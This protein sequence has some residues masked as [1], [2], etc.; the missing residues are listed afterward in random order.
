MYRYTTIFNGLALA[1]A[2]LVATPAVSF[3]AEDPTLDAFMCYKTAIRSLRQK[4]SV[5][6]S[7]AF[8]ADN[9]GVRKGLFLCAPADVEGAGVIDEDTHLVAYRA[10]GQHNS[11]SNVELSDLFGSLSFNTSKRSMM[12]MVPTAKSLDG[13]AGDP[14]PDSLV[15]HFRCLRA[16]ETE[17]TPAFEGASVTVVDQ[18][19][20]RDVEVRQVR[21]ICVPT[22]KNDEGIK[23]DSNYLICYRVDADPKSVNIDAQISNQFGATKVRV[24]RAATLCMPPVPVC[25]PTAAD[26][27]TC[28][29]VD[30]DCDDLVDEDYASTA[31]SCGVGACAA[32]GS[33]SCVA[34]A[35][36]DSC[37][38]G[39]P[40]N[41]DATC[42]GVDDDCD[43]A[44]DEDYV[45]QA[46]SCG[47]GACASTG[48]TSCVQGSV[49]DSCSAGSPAQ[50][51]ATCDGVDDDC[52]GTA[53]EDY[54]LNQTY[55]G[56]AQTGFAVCQNG[57]VGDTCVPE[58]EIC[59]DFED[60]NC[61]EQ[62]DEGCDGE[63]G[64]PC[65][66]MVFG[67]ASYNDDFP[68][69]SCEYNPGISLFL[70]EESGQRELVVD[71]N[72]GGGNCI[73]SDSETEEQAVY[74]DITDQEA[75]ICEALLL[76]IADSDNV[77]CAP[78]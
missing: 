34:G 23:D 18:F 50:N 73:L 70:R 65:A 45:S 62:I 53:D 24:K 51:D 74:V 20:T 33:T 6:L 66:D 9:Y 77:S 78:N 76:Q 11:R 42:D 46:T 3:A 10:K 71:R 40:A 75:D 69:S 30:D 36:E 29:G 72:K 67:A 12:L 63:A 13:P 48:S 41:D 2:L 43:G 57:T 39:T 58:E 56:C 44:A 49:A 1:L 26:D 60:N 61:N 31:T 32:S 64:C 27:A 14:D 25:V 38:A 54:V 16:S 7:D 68:A 47:V 17:G 35:V 8:E 15:D 22:N 59:D 37:A 21:S 28:D 5:T 52:N 55:C 4:Q 19:G